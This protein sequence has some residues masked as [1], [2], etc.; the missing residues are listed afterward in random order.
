MVAKCATIIDGVNTLQ[1]SLHFFDVAHDRILA[2]CD[3]GDIQV[4]IGHIMLSPCTSIA[5]ILL[6][7]WPKLENITGDIR[8]FGDISACAWHKHEGD[9]KVVFD[10]PALRSLRSFQVHS[11]DDHYSIEA[12]FSSDAT[13]SVSITD[14]HA[15]DLEYLDVSRP[16]DFYFLRNTLQNPN[17][18][19]RAANL[20][21]PL[22]Q[23]SGHLE[24]SGNPDMAMLSTPHLD[25]A[26]AMKLSNNTSLKVFNSTIARLGSISVDANP[27]ARLSLAQ[28]Q[29]LGGPSLFRNLAFLDLP[30][31]HNTTKPGTNFSF[32]N[33]TFTNLH[34]PALEA[35]ATGLSIKDNPLLDDVNLARLR[36]VDG[37]LTVEANPRLLTFTANR[38]LVVNGSVRLAG[39]FTS[40]Q[41][42]RLEEVAGDFEVFGDSSI[43]C[44]WFD[45]HFRGKV[46]GGRYTCAGNYTLP[47]VA[48]TPST[49]AENPEDEGLSRGAKAGIGA[50]AAGGGILAIGFFVWVLLEWRRKRVRPR[51][52]TGAEIG[53]VEVDGTGRADLP[54]HELGVGAAVSEPRTRRPGTPAW[55]RTPELGDTGM[56][57]EL[58]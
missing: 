35:L 30:S 8:V 15:F 12:S 49:D 18:G 37:D 56:A 38:L 22:R 4:V 47:A 23:V 41:M 14:A 40:V 9:R 58:A 45:D 43:D 6:L 46:V 36:R 2:T 13:I 51:P 16:S 5:S 3:F 55:P 7:S 19:S 53:A 25:S 31:L 57:V 54:G 28:L 27:A 33:N 20:A 21:L 52:S 26:G 24:F 44:S 48:Q 39:L 42:F 34:L 50:G 1:H 32:S 11:L 29:T 17:D 10:F